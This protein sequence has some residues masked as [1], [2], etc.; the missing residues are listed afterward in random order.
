MIEKLQLYLIGDERDTPTERKW[1]DLLFGAIKVVDQLHVDDQNLE[2]TVSHFVD[3]LKV[4]ELGPGSAGAGNHLDKRLRLL[5]EKITHLT[6]QISEKMQAHLGEAL[7]FEQKEPIR[8]EH[9]TDVQSLL[10]F[11][12]LLFGKNAR[13]RALIDSFIQNRTELMQ[14]NMEECYPFFKIPGKNFDGEIRN[15]KDDEKILSLVIEQKIESQAAFR[16]LVRDYPR[17]EIIRYLESVIETQTSHASGSLAKVTRKIRPALRAPLQKSAN[18]LLRMV[19]D[20]IALLKMSDNWSDG[21]WNLLRETHE[22]MRTRERPNR[23]L[24]LYRRVRRKNQPG[25]RRCQCVH[26]GRFGADC[27]SIPTAGQGRQRAL[28]R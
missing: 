25:G 3:A 24:A 1:K 19:R 18:H 22:C 5:K 16:S 7:T 15:L 2:A 20:Q 11:L 21:L 17:H 4:Q 26:P 12:D 9:K 13:H 10:E 6:Q 8:D 14:N 23:A 27:R 28:Y